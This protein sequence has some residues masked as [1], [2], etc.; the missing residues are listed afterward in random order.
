MP[1]LTNLKNQNNYV[2]L[3]NGK[4]DKENHRSFLFTGPKEIISTNNHTRI[5]SCF[6]QIEKVLKQ[7]Y[8]V[9]GF[10]SYEAAAGFE[11]SMPCRKPDTPLLWFGVYEKPKVYDYFPLTP[12]LSL[13]GRGSLSE[14]DAYH[15][16]NLRP[17][18]TKKAYLRDVGKIK[19]HIRAGDTYQV[20][21]TFKYKFNFSGPALSLFSDLCRKQSVSYA[22]LIGFDNKKIL[23]LS[24]EMF[25]RR[26]NNRINVKPMKGTISRGRYNSED[27]SRQRN[28]VNSAKD[29]AEN[30]M[31]VDMLRNDL[32]RISRTGA[33]KTTSLFNA[34][35]YETL[36]Q[37]T[38]T[39]KAKLKNT[40][41]WFE[42][43]R[44]IF[45]SGSV[46]GAP[47]IRTMQI[48]DGLEKA[49]RNIYTGSIGYI[50]PDNEAVFNVAIRTILLDEGKNKG[51]IGIGSGVTVKSDP[52]SEYDE[53]RLKAQFFTGDDDN[54]D[55][56]ETMLWRRDKFFLINLHLRR[57][58][59]TAAFFNYEFLIADIKKRL[60]I[61]SSRFSTKKQYKVK[62]LVS[63][64]GKITIQSCVIGKDK[65]TVKLI[66]FSAKLVNSSDKFLYHK[67]TKR[68]LYNDEYKKA[69][70]R[71][72]ADTIFLNEKNEVTEGC[73]SNIVIQNGSSY[74]TPPTSSGLLNG[75]FRQYLLKSRHLPLK[76]KVLY[77]KDITNAKKLFICNSV[78]GLQ[79]VTLV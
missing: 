33:V 78:K 31:I 68:K 32:G 77:K 39:I 55:L 14:L 45:P 65:H 57:L 6:E 21:Y 29:Q 47:K 16:K 23:S 4:V 51:E 26:K 36:Y 69:V 37:M 5:K 59:D 41:N 73:I 28:L 58:K 62:L 63:K 19:D 52:N 42:L 1:A 66:T 24:P 72:L 40:F 61:H 25:F 53:C 38:S 13:K 2:L 70:D 17:T 34:E 11:S 22:A 3:Y 20:N 48:I 74:Y 64:Y 56:L 10:L 12:A 60:K 54:F 43:F 8:Y 79:E 27:A 7:G 71:G 44:A 46:T 76:E 75:V 9:A 30:I 35:K 50:C 67:T 18:K 15:I 49:P